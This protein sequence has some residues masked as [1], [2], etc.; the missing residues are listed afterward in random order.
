MRLRTNQASPPACAAAAGV[1]G[2]IA[3]NAGAKDTIATVT[4]DKKLNGNDLSLKGS[5]Q[6]AG[7]VFILQVGCRRCLSCR[8]KL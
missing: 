7:D 1:K 8:N 3:Y 6:F 2:T 5:Y 4:I